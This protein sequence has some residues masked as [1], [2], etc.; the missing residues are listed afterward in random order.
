MRL[1]RGRVASAAVWARQLMMQLSAYIPLFIEPSTAQEETLHSAMVGD[2]DVGRPRERELGA[3]G[4][5]QEAGQHCVTAFC[6]Y[7]YVFFA[8]SR[9]HDY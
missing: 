6:N 4:D 7:D 8:I 3:L 1:S 2:D 9:K 5:E